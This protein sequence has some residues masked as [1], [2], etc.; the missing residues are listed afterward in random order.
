MLITR[1][2]DGFSI[3]ADITSVLYL[4]RVRDLARR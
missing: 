4:E 3:L 1:R 2:G